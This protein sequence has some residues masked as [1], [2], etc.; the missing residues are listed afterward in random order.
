M[1]P[2]SLA[3]LAPVWLAGLALA[4]CLPNGPPTG[5]PDGGSS[6]HSG[7]TSHTSASKKRTQPA[8]TPRLAA[9]TAAS[10]LAIAQEDALL[11]EP[12]EDGFDRGSLGADWRTFGGG[13][14]VQDGK[15]CGQKAHNRGIWLT[16]RL[17]TNARIEFEA[18]SASTDGDLKIELWG[19]GVSGATGQ[20]YTNATSYLAI[21]GGWKNTLH[22]LARLDEHGADRLELKLA[23]DEDDPRARPVSPGQVYRFKIERTDGR[24]VGFWVD[25]VLIHRLVDPEPL[26]GHG[27]D[28]FGFNDWEALVCFDHLRVTPLPG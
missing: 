28:H 26:T 9:S 24:T 22:V 21:F 2:R 15:L 12:F 8:Q 10:S 4:G 20:S 6:S 27:H 17:P 7:H 13:W 5:A 11:K 1:P 25:D 23:P 14:R 3:S 16:R 18:Q 19:D